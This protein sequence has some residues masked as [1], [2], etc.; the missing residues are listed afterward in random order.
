MESALLRTDP[1][2]RRALAAAV[3]DDEI[4]QHCISVPKLIVGNSTRPFV[5]LTFDDGPH[6]NRTLDLLDRLRAL[7]VP[8]TFFVVGSKVRNYPEIVERIVLDGHELGNHTFHH[9]RLPRIP[10]AAVGEEIFRTRAILKE[11]VGADI[12][13]FR[14][15]GG[16]YND[17]I[18]HIIQQQNCVNVLWSDDPADYKVGRKPDEIVHFL[19]R[20]ITPGGIVLLHSGLPATVAALP[21]FVKAIRA[22]GYSFVTVSQLVAL[23]GG[24]VNMPLTRK[25][26]LTS[27]H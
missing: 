8:A 25:P 2:F 1:S 22:K 3:H 5:A 7:N 13:L 19:L 10:L 26:S 15:P 14:P 21:T 17:D 18:Q 4:L 23:S 6:G 11:V 27:A 20:D 16:E 24:I 12:R 9:F